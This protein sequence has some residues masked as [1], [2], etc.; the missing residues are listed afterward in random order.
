MHVYVVTGASR[1]LGSALVETL[2]HADHR[3]IGIARSPNEALASA[4]RERGAWLD[5]YLQDF[6]DVAAVDALGRSIGADL[7]PAE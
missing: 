7:R 6:V 2:L 4:A 1:G 3:V 5:W